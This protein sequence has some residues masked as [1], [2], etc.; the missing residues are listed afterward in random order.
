MNRDLDGVDW[1]I[2]HPG[3]RGTARSPKI[4]LQVKSWSNPVLKDG[5][6]RYRLS[7]DHYNKIAGA[8]FQVVPQE[9]LL[10]VETL[11]ALLGG[12]LEGKRD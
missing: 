7:V 12:G 11:D 5:A 10:T 4:E 9:N 2:A 6:Y 8:G 1:Q 3:P